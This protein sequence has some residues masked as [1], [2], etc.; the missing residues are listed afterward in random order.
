MSKQARLKSYE[1]WKGITSLDILRL[2]DFFPEPHELTPPFADE[3]L[4]A[5][6]SLK[7]QRCW[8]LTLS[9]KGQWAHKNTKPLCVSTCKTCSNNHTTP[10]FSHINLVNVG[11][12]CSLNIPPK[13]VLKPSVFS[14]RPLMGRSSKFFDAAPYVTF[15]TMYIST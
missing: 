8:R 15:I 4:P 13:C 10:S 12:F 1:G 11:L 7:R 2:H 5:L 6:T 3:F 14:S 9:T